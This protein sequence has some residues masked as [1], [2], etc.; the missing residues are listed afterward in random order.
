MLIFDSEQSTANV[1]W[2]PNGPQVNWGWFTY[3][4]EM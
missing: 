3:C 4:L 1:G 2:G